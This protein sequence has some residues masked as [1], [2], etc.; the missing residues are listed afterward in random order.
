[1]LEDAVDEIVAFGKVTGLVIIED[2][3][4][5]VGRFEGGSSEPENACRGCF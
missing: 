1:M 2:W 4:G 3:Y 5:F